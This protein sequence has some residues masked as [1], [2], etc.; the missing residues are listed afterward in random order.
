MAGE[1]TAKT[2]SGTRVSVGVK[3]VVA[4]VA[5]LLVVAAGVFFALSAQNQELQLQ[6]KE[7]TARAVSNLLADSVAASVVFEDSEG[8]A[9]ALGHVGKNPDVLFA[10]VWDSAG[11]TPI[12]DY[13]KEGAPKPGVGPGT[14]PEVNVVRGANEIRVTRGVRDPQGKHVAQALVVFSLAP[15]NARIAELR[16]Q[17]LWVA[18]GVA[19]AVALLLALLT[20]VI[21][22]APLARLMS[23]VAAI[24]QG[25]YERVQVRSNDEI[26]VLATAFNQMTA[27]IQE[28]EIKIA[29]ANRSMREVLDNVEQGLVAVD[30]DGKLLTEWSAALVRWFGE[31][32]GGEPFADFLGRIDAKAGQ[33]FA[34]GWD[35]V[36]SGFMPIELLIDQLPSI[37]E[38]RG[39]NYRIAYQAVMDG[40]QLEKLIVVVTD[41]TAE[42]ERQR[43]EEAQRELME[44][45]R[46]LTTDRQALMAFVKEAGSLNR[47]IIAPDSLDDLVLLKRRVHTLKGNCSLFGLQGISRFLH[48]LESRMA[49]GGVPSRAEL[50]EVGVRWGEIE[51]RTASLAGSFTDVTL[52]QREHAQFVA[53]LEKRGQKELARRVADWT[54]MSVRSVLEHLGREASSLAAR[55]GKG[56]VFVEVEDDGIRVDGDRFRPFFA[57]LAH[58]VRNAVDHG[59]ETPDERAGVGKSVH[60]LLRLKAKGGAAL[61]LELADDG[62]GIDWS[63]VAAKA[64]AAGL[65]NATQEQ[66]V[67]AL[68]SDGVSTK[69][70]V[71]ETSG[72]GIG[73]AQ[74][75]ESVLAL[76][77]KLTV[78]SDVGK[79]TTFRFELP[80]A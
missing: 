2:T 40:E 34:M 51:E 26:G 23:A 57:S 29:A 36:K 8:T 65:P 9:T 25:R 31:P 44:L 77:G 63:R 30:G 53:E 20:Q 32:K 19:A 13:Q 48:D 28:R 15:E 49:E 74:V 60:G 43:A 75:K 54:K 27:A 33:W 5:T 41:I 22:A 59:L 4:T 78:L 70:E 1:N 47:E 79:G 72:R 24:G 18:G 66:L 67:D 62:K 42:L 52:S 46:R 73:L 39:R 16:K 64:A 3:I 55:L 10:G 21:V 61:T 68:F 56:S 35:D 45:F 50:E 76:N 14:S 69:D 80:A 37:V 58:I 17:T 71:S 12:K 6:A 11:Q 7:A 38:Q